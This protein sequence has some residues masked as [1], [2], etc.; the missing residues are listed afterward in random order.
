MYMCTQLNNLHSNFTAHNSYVN[1]NYITP[2]LAPPRRQ[3]GESKDEKRL[4]KQAVKDERRVRTSVL[5]TRS[6][7]M[8]FFSTVTSSQPIRLQYYHAVC[9]GY[10][11][12][13]WD[14]TPVLSRGKCHC[15]HYASEVRQALPST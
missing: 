2:C 5:L 9:M 15:F 6:L 7:P 11:P 8:N 1:P 10:I 14:I 4:R 12:A 3:P 13:Q